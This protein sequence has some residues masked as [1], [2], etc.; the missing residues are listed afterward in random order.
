MTETKK[1]QK[2]NLK[3]VKI[4]PTRLVG[5]KR[6]YSNFVEVTKTNRE[7]SLKFCD[8]R[9]PANEDEVKEVQKNGKIE[10]PIE[11]EIVLPI[12]IGNGIIKALTTQL[13]IKEQ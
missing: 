8:V 7:L 10:A 6:V 11:V 3:Q 1:E 4:I 12:E 9:P 13:E 2:N 5:S